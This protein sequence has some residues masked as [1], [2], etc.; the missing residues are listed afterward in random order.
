[1]PGVRPGPRSRPQWQRPP[2]H[3][4]AA[5]ATERQARQR[6]GTG[7][8]EALP[9][10]FRETLYDQPVESIADENSPID[11]AILADRLADHI[12]ESHARRAVV[13]QAIRRRPGTAF[14]FDFDFP[15]AMSDHDDRV[16]RDPVGREQLRQ[17]FERVVEA[18]HA[19]AAD[20]RHARR[21]AGMLRPGEVVGRGEHRAMCLR[22]ADIP[23]AGPRIVVR[24][25]GVLLSA[26]TVG[27]LRP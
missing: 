12:L 8:N 14:G 6:N 20:Q 16:G 4:R 26:D 13:R 11:P 17:R 1:M 23:G 10:R 19:T 21:D 27:C 5:C 7:D 2:P 24:G 9:E 3:A 22:G 25:P 18:D 15:S